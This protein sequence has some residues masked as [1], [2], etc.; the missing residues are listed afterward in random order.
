MII[1]AT[2]HINF[3]FQNFNIENQNQGE[4]NFSHAKHLS[5]IISHDNADSECICNSV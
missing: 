2:L 3:K 1:I 5:V 4:H